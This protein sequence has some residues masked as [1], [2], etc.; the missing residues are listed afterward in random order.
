MEKTV[1]KAPKPASTKAPPPFQRPSTRQ[2]TK[3]LAT[4]S[5]Q[6]HLFDA[7]ESVFMLQDDNVKA[8]VIEAGEWDCTYPF[9][10]ERPN[11]V[12]LARSYI[13]S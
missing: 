4:V 1:I 6:L 3:V 5:A 10:L 11:P 9:Y 8:S 13:W 12:R 2:G 7:A